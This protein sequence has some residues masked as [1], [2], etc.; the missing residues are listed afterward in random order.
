MC[1]RKSLISS[2]SSFQ[3][4]TKNGCAGTVNCFIS[5]NCFKTQSWIFPLG[6]QKSRI[7]VHYFIVTA[8]R[9]VTSDTH[10]LNRLFSFLQ[11]GPL[12]TLLLC[13]NRFLNILIQVDSR[14]S[15]TCHSDKPRIYLE[16]I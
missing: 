6:I 5:V 2:T 16:Q 7:S 3:N 4:L 10:A 15:L 9:V 11:E 12:I 13:V 8:I 1:S 14:L